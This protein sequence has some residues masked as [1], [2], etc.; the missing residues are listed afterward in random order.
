M[1]TRGTLLLGLGVLVSAVVT[2]YGSRKSAGEDATL[3]GQ[4]SGL[5]CFLEGE[6]CA[7]DHFWKKGEVAGLVTDDFDWYYLSGSKS[8]NGIPRDVLG[9]F[10]LTRVKVK[11][12]LYKDVRTFVRPVLESWQDKAWKMKWPEK[13]GGG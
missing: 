5:E 7:P 3:E 1:K 4:I 2:L 9:K 12:T 8:G 10:F 13:K 11:G 6:L